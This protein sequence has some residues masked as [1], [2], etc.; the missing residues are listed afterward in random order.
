MKI[1]GADKLVSALKERATLDD[2]FN[3]VK[4]N[5]SELEK[6]MRKRAVF[7]GH[8]RG[9]RFIKSTGATARSIYLDVTDG[10]LTSTVQPKMEYAPYLEYGTRFMSAQPFVRPSYAEQ[11]KIF[12][13]DMMRLMK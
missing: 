9:N 11:K 1:T 2:V 7:K 8:Y 6:K 10:G 12:I 4:M 5:G 3:T 13:K